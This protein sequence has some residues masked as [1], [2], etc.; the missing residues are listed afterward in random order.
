MMCL[1]IYWFCNSARL[2]H[3]MLIWKKVYPIDSVNFK[4]I[5]LK[6]IRCDVNMPSHENALLFF[7]VPSTA[8]A[9]NQKMYTGTSISGIGIP[10]AKVGA[11]NRKFYNKKGFA[12]YKDSRVYLTT[13]NIRA[14]SYDDPQRWSIPVHSVVE[15]R[16]VGY[17]NTVD[18]EMSNEYTKDNFNDVSENR[19]R[20]KFYSKEEA[21]YFIHAVWTVRFNGHQLYNNLKPSDEI[22]KHAEPKILTRRDRKFY[23]R[24]LSLFPELESKSWLEIHRELS[25]IKASD[26]AHRRATNKYENEPGRSSKGF[27]YKESNES[28]IS[29]DVYGRNIDPIEELEKKKAENEAIERAL[30]NERK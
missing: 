5:P 30:K 13:V 4:S 16:I 28:V 29:R 21:L 6:P 15:M 24:E 23:E 11:S 22:F 25:G 3:G 26:K 14:Y 27:R 20:I 1:C 10:F 19:Y 2:Y 9:V 7:E 8:V 18:I 12:N 17:G